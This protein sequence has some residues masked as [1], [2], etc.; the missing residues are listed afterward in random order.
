MSRQHQAEATWLR[1]KGFWQRA[2]S[3]RHQEAAR[4]SFVVVFPTYSANRSA[5]HSNSLSTENV[6][7]KVGFL[8]ESRGNRSRWTCPPLPSARRWGETK[9]TECRADIPARRSSVSRSTSRDRRSPRTQIRKGP[10]VSAW[11]IRLYSKSQ[12]AGSRWRPPCS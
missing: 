2:R 11:R 1:S 6:G 10:G 3:R 7:S 9:G 12:M 4:D 8:V 5:Y